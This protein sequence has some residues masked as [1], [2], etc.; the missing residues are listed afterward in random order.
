MDS[1]KEVQIVLAM[2][3]TNVKVVPKL[4]LTVN[5]TTSV[6][7]TTS[8][9][10]LVDLDNNIIEDI[11]Y[12]NAE[13]FDNCIED[14][15]NKESFCDNN[16]KLDN[17]MEFLDENIE[18]V[19]ISDEPRKLKTGQKSKIWVKKSRKSAKVSDKEAYSEILCRVCSLKFT[20]KSNFMSHHKQNH[21]KNSEELQYQCE[22][23]VSRYTNHRNLERHRRV[24]HGYVAQTR[25]TVR[26]TSNSTL[27]TTNHESTPDP[28][29]VKI[30]DCSQCDRMFL[31][32]SGLH[33]HV[34]RIHKGVKYGC[35]VCSLITGYK[36]SMMKHCRKY[37]HDDK[38]IF[39]IF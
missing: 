1:L 33:K 22:D 7:A 3:G 20:S 32:K 28:N 24:K 4:L 19:V 29:K 39:K 31:H 36:T 13:E 30:F 16:E 21:G 18:T 17:I 25:K 23:C 35:G 10:H 26:K 34:E 9:D 14:G 38:L 5:E 6:V 12:N 15:I 27:V 8:D 11:D 37:G 2:L